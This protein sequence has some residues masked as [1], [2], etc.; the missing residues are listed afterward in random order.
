METDWRKEDLKSLKNCLKEWDKNEG[1]MQDSY[2][3]GLTQFLEESNYN[4][5]SLCDF[6][7]QSHELD[8]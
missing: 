5:G 7:A 6:I 3:N 1:D 8:F 2:P 4:Y